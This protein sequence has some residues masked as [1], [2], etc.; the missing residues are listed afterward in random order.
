MR[1][2]A[3]ITKAS[4]PILGLHRILSGDYWVIAVVL[5]AILVVGEG[6]DELGRILV[7]HPVGRHGR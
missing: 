1:D 2:G 5:R 4:I 3:L 7:N 6:V